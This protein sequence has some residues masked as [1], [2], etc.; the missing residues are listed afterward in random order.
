MSD[1]K[2]AFNSRLILNIGLAVVVLMLVLV[3]VFEPG[4]APPPEK[5]RLTSLKQDDIK[6]IHIKR[7]KQADIVLEKRGPVWFMLKPYHLAANDFRA[8]SIMQL[9]EAESHLQYDTASIDLAKF[10]LKTATTSVTFNN[11]LTLEMGNS[12]PLQRRRY[13]RNGNTLHLITDNLY[14]NIIATPTS[15]LSYQLL[16]PDSKFSKLELPNFT[17]QLEQGRWTVTPTPKDLSAD[18]ITE[19]LNEWRHAQALEIEEYEGP[20]KKGQFKIHLQGQDSP[21][22]FSYTR[23]EDDH[24]LIR[25]DLKLRYKISEEIAKNLQELPPPPEPL[26][27]TTAEDL[28]TGT[29][30]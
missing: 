5:V 7:N 13:V 15:F 29:R 23:E 28:N 10:D 12:D 17:M 26:P 25:H 20:A 21:I 24:Y 14:Y 19:L 22:G 3:V 30:K 4:K 6:Q 11:T 2:N 16:P 9:A 8:K 1:N 27:E 18:S